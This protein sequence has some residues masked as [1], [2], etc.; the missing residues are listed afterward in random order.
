MPIL[1]TYFNFLHRSIVSSPEDIQRPYH[2]ITN[3]VLKIIGLIFVAAGLWLNWLAMNLYVANASNVLE[4]GAASLAEKS[5]L[6]S[7]AMALSLFGISFILTGSF[8][9]L[10]LLLRYIAFT[11]PDRIFKRFG[12]KNISQDSGF[13][14]EREH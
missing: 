14:D 12:S 11:L 1:K 5:I 9:G 8:L 7:E 4:L 3:L 6:L 13:Q 2:K 10:V